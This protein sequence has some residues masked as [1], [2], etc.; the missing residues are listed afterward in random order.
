M[1]TEAYE[2]EL[3]FWENL[4]VEE[5][6]PEN[7]PEGLID[8]MYEQIAEARAN[9]GTATGPEWAKVYLDPLVATILEIQSNY[10]I[11]EDEE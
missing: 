10:S 7:Q 3:D 6:E 2:W 1:S 11:V 8:R 9:L 5:F 4:P